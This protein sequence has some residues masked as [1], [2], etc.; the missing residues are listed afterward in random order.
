MVLGVLHE[1][2]RKLRGW[3]V[4][5]VVSEGL[6]R[7]VLTVWIEKYG[8][9]DYKVFIPEGLPLEKPLP[10]NTVITD[11]FDRS[12]QSPLGTGPE[13]WSWSN[14]GSGGFSIVG[15]R[16]RNDNSNDVDSAR[17]DSDLSS[18]DHYVEGDVSVVINKRGGLTGRFS[19]GGSLP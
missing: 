7:K 1:N 14:V 4:A 11:D 8:I 18:A 6:H 19:R 2:Y 15:N 17:A 3:T 16:A 13:A 9:S 10:H 12:D 5:G